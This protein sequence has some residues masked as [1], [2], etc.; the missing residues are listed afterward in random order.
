MDEDKGGRSP[1]HP[2]GHPIGHGSSPARPT[3]RAHIATVT[4]ARAVSIGR[5]QRHRRA[6]LLQIP[7]PIA[8]SGRQEAGP[9]APGGVGHVG[10]HLLP[11]QG[12]EP[13]DEPLYRAL[14]DPGAGRDSFSQPTCRS[15]GRVLRT[16]CSQ[17]PASAQPRENPVQLL[18]LFGRSECRDPRLRQMARP[19][20]ARWRARLAREHRGG[21]TNRGRQRGIGARDHGLGGPA[22]GEPPSGDNFHSGVGVRGSVH[23]RRLGCRFAGVGEHVGHRALRGYGSRHEHRL[24]RHRGVQAALRQPREVVRLHPPVEL[25]VRRPGRDG[26]R[27]G[28]G[29]HTSIG[30]PGRAGPASRCTNGAFGPA[31]FA[32]RG[33]RP[34]F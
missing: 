20:L 2:K 27:A 15:G 13:Q 34:S 5:A 32:V 28:R 21:I 22:V 7:R 19:G 16:V 23:G 31:V 4:L 33:G 17:Y 1:S 10:Q 8:P 29:A 18:G 24:P 11:G 3:D 6:C 26:Y 25:T 9:L 30:R 12:A 14:R